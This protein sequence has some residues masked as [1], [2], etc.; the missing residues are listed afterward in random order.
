[1]VL[2]M[3]IDK[4]WEDSFDL[5]PTYQ[6]ERAT[7]FIPEESQH[8]TQVEDSTSLVAARADHAR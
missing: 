4:D 5:A 7:L 1:M 3:F 6:R 8:T 2:E